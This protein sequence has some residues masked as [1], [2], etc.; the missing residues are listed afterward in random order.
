MAKVATTTPSLSRRFQSCAPM[1]IVVEAGTHSPWVSRL[2]AQW[3]HE[4][5]VANPRK[6]R[7]IRNSRRKND[8]TVILLAL[9]G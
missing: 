4:V 8:R 6:V 9:S 1:R 3:G 7:L 2:L 5:I